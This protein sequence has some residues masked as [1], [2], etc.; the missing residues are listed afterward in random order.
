MC[1]IHTED[2]FG[3]CSDAF[4]KVKV[5]R[6]KKRHFWPFRRPT[7]RLFGSTSLASSSSS[8]CTR[9]E[10]LR[11]GSMFS[12]SRCHSGHPTN[13]VKALKNSKHKP[14]PGNPQW[15]QPFFIHHWTTEWSGI[16]LFSHA[17]SNIFPKRCSVQIVLH[18]FLFHG[19]MN[20]SSEAHYAVSRSCLKCIGSAALVLERASGLQKYCSSYLERFPLR[21]LGN[22]YKL[23]NGNSMCF[24]LHLNYNRTVKH[25]SMLQCRRR[26]CDVSVAWLKFH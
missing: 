6:D 19:K 15:F 13:S 3:P 4:L 1:Q 7:C 18:V 5:T 9:R 24:V 21:R 12:S 22:P 17:A 23:G 14:Q 11:I 26:D 20:K 2:V 25:T 16:A 10:P 8:T